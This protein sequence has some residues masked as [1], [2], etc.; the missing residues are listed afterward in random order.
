MDFLDPRRRRNHRR[1]LMIGYVLMSIL[2]GLGTMLILYLAYGWDIDRKTG[3]LIQNGIVF[4]D[5][6]PRGAK[7]FLNDKEQ[8]SATDT[9]LV[10]PAGVHTIRLEREG[11]RHW[12]RTF[13]LEGGEIERLVYPYL[14]PNQFVTTDVRQY[15]VTPDLVMQSPDRR[16]V[17]V[18]RP[19][20]TYQFDVIDL[21]DT[22]RTPTSIIVPP[23]I[24]TEPSAE[25]SLSMVEWSN[26]NRHVLIRRV[27]GTANEYLMLDRENPA[28]SININNTLGITPARIS[29]RD[30]R[31]DQFYYLDAVP[32]TLRIANTRDRTISAPLVGAVLEYKSY[33]EDI[34]LYATQE[35]A[36][37]GKIDFRILEGNQSYVLKSLSQA[38]R[39]ILEVSRYNS[40]WYYVVGS[41]ADNLAYVYENPLPS[42]KN[43]T[44]TPLIVAAIMRLDNPRFVSFSAFGQ[45][46]VLQSGNKFLTLDLEDR[47]QYRT[48]LR[49]DISPKQQLKWMDAYRLIYTV[50][51]QSYIIDFD[52]SNEE[53]LVTSQQP[54]GPFFDPG[55][56]NVLTFEAAKSAPGK[57]A[58]TKTVIE[59]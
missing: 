44:K 46:I 7:I 25:A 35:G 47:N 33:A 13:S 52:G 20:L 14:L 40:E 36:S 22:R 51:S 28:E 30:K 24:L 17:L 29:L 5:T 11:Y 48:D 38:D 50:N 53:T 16:W 2:V 8:S 37:E 12:E 19:G 21:E 6:K 58:L 31:P 55:Y 54:A 43:Q 45:F 1:R 3:T 57:Q 15:D 23:A 27:Y 49:H 10:L 42:L 34:V 56:D 39:Y 18:Q 41:A 9:R 4:V 59:E 26:D 32:G